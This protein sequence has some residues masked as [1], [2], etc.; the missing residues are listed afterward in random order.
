MV[1][2]HVTEAPIPTQI[3]DGGDDYDHE[4]HHDENCPDIQLP[5]DSDGT[6]VL[7]DHCS[8]VTCTSPPDSTG[9]FSHMV[10]A[11]QAYGCGHQPVKA[12]VSLESSSVKWSHTF[13]DGEKTAM[14]DSLKPPDVP[15][16][17]KIF[18]EVE[19]KKNGGKVHFKVQ[20]SCI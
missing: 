3:S 2:S 14:P 17:V 18:L 7:D 19:L 11:V 5:G 16:D 1:V 15:A 4:G 13:K 6:C 9:S 20:K 10:L 12:K 8:K